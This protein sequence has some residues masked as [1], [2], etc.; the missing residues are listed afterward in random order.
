MD[1]KLDAPSMCL[2]NISL[3]EKCISCDIGYKI[4]PRYHMLFEFFFIYSYLLFSHF[5]TKIDK[6][7]YMQINV[8]VVVKEK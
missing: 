2:K 4:D 6:G 8:I 3:V 1:G 5:D 7:E